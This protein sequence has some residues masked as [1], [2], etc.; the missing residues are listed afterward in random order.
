MTT[1]GA[2]SSVSPG[3]RGQYSPRAAASW[4][5]RM[6]E[7]AA[8]RRT[9][10]T[11]ATSPGVRGGS[12][13]ASAPS[14]SARLRSQIAER[15]ASLTSIPQRTA[16][17]TNSRI[18][19]ARHARRGA[20]VSGRVGCRELPARSGS[21]RCSCHQPPGRSHSTDRQPQSPQHNSDQERGSSRR[22]CGVPQAEQVHTSGI[23]VTECVM[24]VGGAVVG[25][26]C[27]GDASSVQW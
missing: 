7:T 12:S 9:S 19:R 24:V 20:P 2:A 18:A 13:A 5:S 17:G 27:V 4:F 6:S 22:R 8:S 15:T 3:G 14:E 26:V 10:K 23:S 21:P 1:N 25:S 16:V 11:S